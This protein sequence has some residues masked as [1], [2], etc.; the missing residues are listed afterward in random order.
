MNRVFMFV[1]RSGGDQQG[2]RRIDRARKEGADKPDPDQDPD[3]RRESQHGIE[4]RGG[5]TGPQQHDLPSEA[6]S[7]HPPDRGSNA[8]ARHPGKVICRNENPADAVIDDM[9]VFPQQQRNERHAAAESH[10]GEKLRDPDKDQIF[11]PVDRK[12]RR[13]V[14]FLLCSC[15][16]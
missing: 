14:H 4:D 9:E 12:P 11:F 2:L 1:G 5:I 6:V 3:I 13:I 7:K 10:H 16:S 8:E 15:C